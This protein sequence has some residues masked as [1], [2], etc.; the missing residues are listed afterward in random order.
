[1]AVTCV[2]GIPLGLIAGLLAVFAIRFLA[3]R[4]P[5][6][7]ELNLPASLRELVEGRRGMIYGF[8]DFEGEVVAA[9]GERPPV[10][11]REGDH[12]GAHGDG[13]RGRNDGRTGAGQ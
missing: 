8:P 1:M 3:D 7:E 13:R 6:L 4:I 10:G 11:H 9:V 2:V 5:S 12:R